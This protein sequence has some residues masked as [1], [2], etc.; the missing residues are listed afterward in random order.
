MQGLMMDDYQLTLDTILSRAERLFPN[1]KIVTRAPDRSIRSTDYASVIRRARALAAAILEEGLAPG[2][3]I[4]TLMWNH[5]TH[6]E[7]YLGVPAAG[8]VLHT[9][10]LRLPADDLAY[11]INHAHD[12]WIIADDILLPILQRVRDRIQPD[13][14]FVVP[15]S[16]QK[17]PSGLEDYD[18]F[19]ARHQP[20]TTLPTLGERDAAGLCYTSGTTGRLKGVLYSHRALVL[21]SFSL[22][23]SLGFS[24]GDVGLAVVPMF[25]VNG[26]GIPYA[27]SMLGARQVLP[28]P[29]LDPESLIDLMEREQVTWASGV[30]SIWFGLLEALEANP[31]RWKLSPTLRMVIGGSAVPEAMIR[32]FDRLGIRVIQGYGM[33]ETSPVVTL[34]I[35]KAEM[36]NWPPDRLYPLLARQGLPVPF[37]DV[38]IRGEKGDLPWDGKSVGE[39]E[40]R[41]PWVAT[42]YYNE[43]DQQG[44]WTE[45]GWLR[46]GDVGTIDSE[47][48]LEIVDRVKDLVK[49][50]G[51]WISSVAL[52]NA[53]VGHPAVREAAIIA[54]PDLKWGERPIAFVVFKEGARATDEELRSLLSERYPKWWLPDEF[55]VVPSLPK[56]STGKV[57][58]LTLRE[59]LKK[60]PSPSASGT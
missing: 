53:L 37:A 13:R 55:R 19:L 2:D 51:E 10:N 39:L 43:P 17:V 45:D 33:T 8:A 3:R 38:R 4:A 28:G 16:G 21:H 32:R 30:P 23:F 6:L 18:E 46:T 48:F 40:V 22:G 60:S 52:E 44:K 36:R 12:R 35:P 11:V 31:G 49:S 14:V 56:T 5:S 58:K 59:E 27:F 29:H 1:V 47:G 24:Q 50:G 15:F 7:A 34:G 41:G 25:H 42:S 26:W 9:L 54:R 20:R 57:S